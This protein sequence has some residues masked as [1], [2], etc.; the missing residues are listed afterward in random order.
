MDIISPIII[1]RLYLY[2]EKSI[3]SS[4][5]LQSELS[6]K[7]SKSFF[8]NISNFFIKIYKEDCIE[9]YNKHGNILKKTLNIKLNVDR[10]NCCAIEKDLTHLLIQFD[11]KMILIINLKNERVCDILHFDFTNLIGMT[12]IKNSG[13]LLS[14]DKNSNSLGLNNNNQISNESIFFLIFPNKINI[15]KIS[16]VPNENV[17]EIKRIKH[18]TIITNALFNLRFDV[19]LLEKGDKNYEFYN[20]SN[21]KFYNKPHL[22]SINSKKNKEGSSFSRLLGIFSSTPEDKNSSRLSIQNN[23]K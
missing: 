11:N 21:E 3:K 14:N 10:V 17:R 1:K 16:G 6:S 19:L 8:D 9:I 12:F 22:F 20:F 23:S 7:K 4:K 5:D 13:G 18:S 15:F 2:D